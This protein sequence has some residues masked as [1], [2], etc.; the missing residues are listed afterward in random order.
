MVAKLLLEFGKPGGG[1]VNE[2]LQGIRILVVEDEKDTMDLVA[3]VLE[4]QKATVVQANTVVSALELFDS[5]P[6]NIIVA[7]IG[8][9]DYNG[10][11][12]VTSIREREAS[13]NQRTPVIAL[14]AFSL[15]N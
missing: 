6:P 7:D 5:Q 11:A 10:Y 12:L 15:P 13:G 9:P 8:M 4:R 1:K 14:T 3:F 2:D